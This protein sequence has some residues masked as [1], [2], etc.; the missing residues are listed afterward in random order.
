MPRR[1][2]REGKPMSKVVI[3]IE[4]GPSGEIDVQLESDPPFPGPAA[5]NKQGTMAQSWGIACLQWIIEHAGK[6]RKKAVDEKE[7]QE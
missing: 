4:D 1:K 2:L 5:K 6:C 3:T 7:A